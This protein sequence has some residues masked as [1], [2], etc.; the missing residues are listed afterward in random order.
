MDG[1]VTIGG[2]DQA[3]EYWDTNKEY[4]N[5]TPGAIEFIRQFVIPDIE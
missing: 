2:K 5:N 3:Y 1:Y 4:W